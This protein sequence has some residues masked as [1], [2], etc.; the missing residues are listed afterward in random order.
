M[1]A[2]WLMSSADDD[3]FPRL[4]DLIAGIASAKQRGAWQRDFATIMAEDARRWARV[5]ATLA[6]LPDVAWQ[7]LK[8][9]ILCQIDLR[10]PARGWLQAIPLLNEARAYDH[11]VRLGYQDVAFL[12]AQIH[13]KSPDLRATRDDKVL[14]CEVKTLRLSRRDSLA[15]NLHVKLAKRLSDA[16]Q[17][18]AAMDGASDAA[19][20][21]YIV[22][23]ISEGL[24]PMADEIRERIDIYLAGA[25][26]AGI[27]VVIDENVT[28]DQ[29]I[30]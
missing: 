27:T 12:A 14:F 6:R 17:Q 26:L 20:M 29:V 28:I 30:L 21:I 25:G 1:R 4:R 3:R 16:V 11:L 5:E 10:D 9:T 13:A 22:L 8:A 23:D 24:R 2:S 15:G 7:S 18:L 19:R